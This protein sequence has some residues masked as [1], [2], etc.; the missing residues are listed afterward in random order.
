MPLIKFMSVEANA[1]QTMKDQLD[2]GM[3]ERRLLYCQYGNTKWHMTYYLGLQTYW[4]L[5]LSDSLHELHLHL[6][7]FPCPFVLIPQ[8]VIC[9]WLVLDLLYLSR[10]CNI[11]N[12][13]D[14]VWP[15]FQSA[16]RKLK[17]RY[18]AE[19]FKFNEPEGVWKCD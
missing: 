16:K 2:T 6:L 3:D 7:R 17:T 1:F 13:W 18:V 8:L 4:M 11:S 19:Y 15:Y 9:V 14:G 10:W 5:T 12:T